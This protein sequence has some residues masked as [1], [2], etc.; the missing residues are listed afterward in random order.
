MRYC[1]SAAAF[2]ARSCGVRTA[3]GSGISSPSQPWVSGVAARASGAAVHVAPTNTA[4]SIAAVR[5]VT[6]YTP[7]KR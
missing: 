2:T 7:A 4:P 1:R 6:S 5:I 3:S